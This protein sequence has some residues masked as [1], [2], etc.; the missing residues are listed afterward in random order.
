[1]KLEQASK[2]NLLFCPS[3]RFT[4][5]SKK[6]PN[7]QKATQR[8]KKSGKRVFDFRIKLFLFMCVDKPTDFAPEKRKE[9]NGA[10][11][12]SAAAYA[13]GAFIGLHRQ[14]HI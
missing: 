7:G 8:T 14:I 2:K 9:Q 1:V 10:E 4:K 5:S 6:L 13:I 11:A 3:R 12:A